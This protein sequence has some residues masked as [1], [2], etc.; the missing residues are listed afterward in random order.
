MASSSPYHQSGPPKAV[1]F[2]SILGRTQLAASRV[3]VYVARKV[4]LCIVN[5]LNPSPAASLP[6]FALDP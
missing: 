5:L 2:L 3:T 4:Q 6:L 1:V